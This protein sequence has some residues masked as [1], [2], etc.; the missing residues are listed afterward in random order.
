[1]RIVQWVLGVSR[2]GLGGVYGCDQIIQDV[3]VSQR[4]VRFWESG[5]CDLCELTKK[6]RI[7]SNKECGFVE[8]Q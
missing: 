3:K 8:S 6:I 4:C 7:E 1:M 2:S 5:D